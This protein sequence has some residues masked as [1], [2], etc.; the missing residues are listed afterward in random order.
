MRNP[1][2]A[3]TF[4]DNYIDNWYNYLPLLD[5]FGAKVTFYISRYH[6][7][8]PAQKNKLSIIQSK[9]HEIA[10]HTTH[11][12][13]MC[14]YL[15]FMTMDDLEQHEIY[16]DLNRMRNDGF[17]PKTFAYPTVNTISCSMTAC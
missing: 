10:F 13:H 1:G 8:T 9:G 14:Q 6:R 11:H 16:E 12:L 17:Y 7:L 4:D 5:S 3:L 15:Q 2:I